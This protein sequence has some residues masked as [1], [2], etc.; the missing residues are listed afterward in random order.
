M[1]SS[2]IHTKFRGR[3]DGICV[4][5]L[6]FAEYN[7][8]VGGEKAYDFEDYAFFYG[9][10]LILSR[11]DDTARMNYIKSYM[12]VLDISRLIKPTP[13]IKCFN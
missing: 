5:P 11:P 6:R 1:L 4:H 12:E 13:I 2:D 3:S 7:S 8:A 10:P 9:T